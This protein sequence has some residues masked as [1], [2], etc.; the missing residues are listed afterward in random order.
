M[1]RET[2]RGERDTHIEERETG[3]ETEWEKYINEDR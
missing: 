2:E 1:K 3:R